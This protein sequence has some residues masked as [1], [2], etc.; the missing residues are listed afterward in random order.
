MMSGVSEPIPP[1]QPP[2]T[3]KR[4]KRWLTPL[5]AVLA[6]LFGYAVHTG[7]GSS[8]DPVAAAPAATVT[9]AGP[10]ATVT[11]P[12]KAGATVTQKAAPGAT[13]TEK[14][15][16]A[17]TV[18][19]QAKPAPTVTVTEGAPAPE[20]PAPKEAKP[21][22]GALTGEQENAVQAAQ[23]YISFSPF[24]R[25]GLIQQLSSD[26]GDGYSKKDA[27]VAVD[28]LN[29]DYNAQAVKAAKNYRKLQA[30]SR[31]GLIEQLSSAAGD[32][33]TKAQA[34]YGA[35]HAQ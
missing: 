22:G 26:A 7:G 33:Y 30:F 25:K 35:N 24:S 13:V 34:E 16:P 5:I 20:A 10:T 1:A 12:G 3:P 4:R 21:G 28:S 31:K 18:T 8:S 6:F 29:I 23:N 2:Q 17:A 11:A 9:Q 19:K 32:S 27:T 15:A 14:A